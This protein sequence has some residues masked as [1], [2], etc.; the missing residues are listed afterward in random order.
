MVSPSLPLVLAFGMCMLP[1]A[2]R[3]L[4]IERRGL[5]GRGPK[6]D[7]YGLECMSFDKESMQD[8]VTAVITT[9]P[10][11]EDATGQGLEVI[12]ATVRS[13]REV[14]GLERAQIILACDGVPVAKNVTVGAKVPARSIAQSY[15]Q[16]IQDFELWNSRELNN[17][18][19]VFK[20]PEWTHQAE[21]TRRVFN[22]LQRKG[23]LT[24]IVF[25][26]QD[27]SRVVGSIDV[28]FVLRH[29]SCDP[30]VDYVRFLWSND[31]TEAPAHFGWVEPCEPHPDTKFLQSTS[32]MSDRPHFATTNL[33]YSQLFSRCPHSFRG[34]PERCWFPRLKNAWIYGER[35][36]MLHDANSLH[37]SLNNHPR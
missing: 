37:D 16:K 4:C 30:K 17:Q 20:N 3:Q 14:L 13:I 25:I 29:L 6:H 2:A 35:Y 28:P 27:D 32:R 26:A 21:M 5:F 31:C 11:R 15:E 23:M 12:K 36:K 7:E 1:C 9:S 22:W 33:Y 10:R 34:V 18:V 8:Q 24:P 19:T